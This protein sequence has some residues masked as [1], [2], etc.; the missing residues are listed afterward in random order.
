MTCLMFALMNFRK[1]GTSLKFFSMFS[2]RISMTLSTSKIVSP[3]V[4]VVVRE[5]EFG[6]LFDEHAVEDVHKSFVFVIEFCIH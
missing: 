5:Q 4:L 1:V 2:V 6:D 3:F